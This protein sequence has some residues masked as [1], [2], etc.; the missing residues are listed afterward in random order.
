MSVMNE[1]HDISF[2][3][4]PIEN[5]RGVIHFRIG[6]FDL[7]AGSSPILV[8]LIC[9]YLF[10]SVMG[11]RMRNTRF[12]ES[13]SLVSLVD[14]IERSSTLESAPDPLTLVKVIHIPAYS[15][16]LALFSAE[17]QEE[18]QSFLFLFLKRN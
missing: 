14:S 12:P 17:Q 11:I 6:F 3:R 5:Q 7:I 16:L 2:L 9:Q 1:K 13:S 10:I 15:I 8:S 4:M 18:P